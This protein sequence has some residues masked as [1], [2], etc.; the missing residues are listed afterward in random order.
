MSINKHQKVKGIVEARKGDASARIKVLG[1]KKN[2]HYTY[3][4]QD[5][6]AEFL[7]DG[8]VFAPNLFLNEDVD[9]NM[10]LEFSV[11]P[12]DYNSGPDIMIFDLKAGFRKLYIPVQVINDE[13]LNHPKSINQPLLKRY[14]P[15]ANGQFYILNLESLYGPFSYSNEEVRPYTGKEVNKYKNI[16]KAVDIEGR[17]F[18]LEEPKE[19][20]EKIDCMTNQQLAGWFRELLKTLPPLSTLDKLPELMETIDKSDLKWARLSRVLGLSN[21]IMLTQEELEKLATTSEPLMQIYQQSIE[22]IKN[23][24]YTSEMAPLQS[25][26]DILSSQCKQLQHQK[27]KLQKEYKKQ[28][29]QKEE[30]EADVEH[31]KT[32]RDIIIK[33]IRI[34]SLLNQNT[35]VHELGNNSACFTSFECQS[36]L[37]TE[38]PFE[39]L[40]DFLLCYSD[41]F[42]SNEKV[43]HRLAL[44]QLRTFRTIL[45][46]APKLVQQI[47]KYSNN[48][49]LYI[50]QVEADW[51]RF[52]SLYDNGLKQ[53]WESAKS[54][55]EVLHFFLLEDINLASIECYAK[56]ILD[57]LEG[58]R[59]SLPGLSPVW[60]SNLWIF[61]SPLPPI[62]DHSFGLPLIPNSFKNWG[63]IPKFNVTGIQRPQDNRY[64]TVK[65]LLEH[66]NEFIINQTEYFI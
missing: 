1:F 59:L 16:P 14:I 28:Q 45:C 37:H 13:I 26:I 43:N 39:N 64:L 48:C 62:D 5:I 34:Q 50:Q 58:I 11:L 17:T 21:E 41:L 55:P 63:A 53:S 3:R 44:F 51:L 15:Q 27:E 31:L 23:E 2:G 35:Q 30:L 60:P 9:L 49:K 38:N 56:P 18:L 40:S 46:S 52:E 42:Q 7:P 54:Q 32:N 65:S 24:I 61:G 8:H 57:F 29:I 66:E 22:A 33:N 20:A 10:L 36:Y 6:E 4:Q 47:A 12:N 25:Q 19:I